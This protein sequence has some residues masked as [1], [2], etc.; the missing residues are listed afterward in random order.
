LY[1][2]R[3]S[4]ELRS[5]TAWWPLR[6][7]E[8]TPLPTGTSM[9]TILASGAHAGPLELAGTASIGQGAP[10]KKKKGRVSQWL[11]FF[12]RLR[13]LL[14]GL[15]QR[16]PKKTRVFFGQEAISQPVPPQGQYPQTNGMLCVVDFLLIVVGVQVKFRFYHS[17]IQIRCSC[18]SHY[19]RIFSDLEGVVLLVMGTV[20]LHEC[21]V[22]RTAA[23]R[24]GF[25]R[26]PFH[27][28]TPRCAARLPDASRFK[29]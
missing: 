21:A 14:V 16:A 26:T 27:G 6:G 15:A 22:C 13:K 25:A 29:I 18:T 7:Y 8:S 1:G 19:S 5:N 17:P 24:T 11:L 3:T 4:L 20:Q 12:R 9:A 2:G 23:V 10:W 28:R